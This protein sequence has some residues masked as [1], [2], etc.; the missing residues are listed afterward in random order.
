MFK[1]KSSPKELAIQL[2][3]YINWKEIF[4][5]HTQKMSGKLLDYWIGN[6]L[7]AIQQKYG[8][9]YMPVKEYIFEIREFKY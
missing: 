1:Y 8:H 9:T 5:I 3:N 7:K 2:A 6:V 4:K